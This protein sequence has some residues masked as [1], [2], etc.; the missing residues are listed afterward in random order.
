MHF[1]HPFQALKSSQKNHK[2]LLLT[3]HDNG[4]TYMYFYIYSTNGQ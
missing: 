3:I 4:L 1:I 2:F